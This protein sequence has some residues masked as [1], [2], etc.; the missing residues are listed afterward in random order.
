MINTNSTTE[1]ANNEMIEHL[2]AL[3][4]LRKAT[5]ATFYNKGYSARQTAV[6]AND[7]MIKYIRRLPTASNS[8][9]NIAREYYLDLLENAQARLL[10][11]AE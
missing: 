7:Y 2:N 8:A 10:E 4:Q 5:E 9:H 3:R 11:T 1:V 6:M